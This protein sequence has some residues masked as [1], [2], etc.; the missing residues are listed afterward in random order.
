MA[1]Y[2]GWYDWKL[3]I[4]GKFV[5]FISSTLYHLTITIR[6]LAT[7]DATATATATATVTSS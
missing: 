2:L 4:Y 1:L 5:L 3:T 7:V 6:I